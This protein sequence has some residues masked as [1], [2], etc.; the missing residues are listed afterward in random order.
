VKLGGAIKWVI[1]LVVGYTVYRY[2]SGGTGYIATVAAN[3]SDALGEEASNL[4]NG[5]ANADAQDAFHMLMAALK[6]KGNPPVG[7][8]AYNQVMLDN[9]RPDLVV[10][11][12]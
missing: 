5:D 7:S 2:V 9:G 4:I 6:A 12:G 11:G 3:V 8:P 10:G 1:A